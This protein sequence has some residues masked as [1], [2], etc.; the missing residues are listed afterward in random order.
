M[1]SLQAVGMFPMCV[2]I[3]FQTILQSPGNSLKQEELD[4]D[5]AALRAGFSQHKAVAWQG[6]DMGEPK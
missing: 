5:S 4:S 3:S 1:R 2:L 6:Q